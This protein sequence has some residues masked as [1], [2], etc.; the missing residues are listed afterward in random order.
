MRGTDVAGVVEA[1]GKNV[2]DLQPGDEVFGSLWDNDLNIHPPGTFAEY[3]VLP[4]SQLIKKPVKLSFED[5]AGSVM[6]GL[7]ALIAIRDVGGVGV[8][9]PTFV[10]WRLIGAASLMQVIGW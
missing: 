6:S 2:T 5:A 3:S 8:A 9:L 7:T 10:A 1:V 4:V